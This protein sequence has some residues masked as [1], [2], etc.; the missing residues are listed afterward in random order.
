M[1]V[2]IGLLT[3]VLLSGTV[4]M[5]GL[6]VILTADRLRAAI[7]FLIYGLLVA[8]VW[9]RLGAP[10]VALTEA[11]I[12]GGMIGLLVLGASTRLPPEPPRS[13]GAPARPRRW[14]LHVIAAALSATVALGL[15]LV[16]LGL[17]EPA[18]SLAAAVAAELPATA[19][20][21][22]VTGVLMAFR[23]VDTLFETV[24]LVLALIAFWSLIPDAGWSRRPDWLPLPHPP[25]ALVLLARILLPIG[26]LV[27]LHLFWI[28]A[29]LPGGKFQA[30][31]L[32]AALWALVMVAGLARPIA[33]TERLVR[34][35]AVLGPLVFFVI[36]LGGLWLAGDFLAYP[37]GLEKPLIIII[38]VVLMLSVA[39][40]LG[41]ILAGLPSADTAVRAPKARPGTEGQP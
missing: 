30:G 40:M 24:V 1:S 16:V 22:P 31:A 14:I 35:L 7:G 34:V 17:P 5:L 39:V 36:G 28:G 27:A 19:L 32:L 18:P 37:E 23:A 26:V 15:A 8:L 11:A 25:P 41:L 4:L 20:E 6:W 3:D 21:N 10:D 13:P 12:G 29:S 33:A 9:V 38:E 2:G